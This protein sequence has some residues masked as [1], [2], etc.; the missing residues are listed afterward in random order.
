MCIR[1]DSWLNPMTVEELKRHV[2]EIRWFHRIDLGDGVVTPGL[3]DTRAKLERLK[4]PESFAG[5]SV[6]DIGAWD[7][8]F[9][10]EAEKR[11]ASRVVAM[12]SFC[13]TGDGWGTKRGFELARRVLGSKV[14]DRE[15]E[16]LDLSPETA[17]GTFDVVFFFGVLY[18]MRHPL[19][20]LEKVSSVTKSH[21]ILETKVDL[22]SWS[23]PAMA[24][25]VGDELNGDPTN[26]WAPNVAG[27][28]DMLR[29]VG[30]KKFLVTSRPPAWPARLAKALRGGTFSWQE[31]QRGRVAMHAWK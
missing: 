17:G 13:W 9:S 31:F 12:D 4:L 1:V 15:L 8:F 20:A 24:F 16:V 2:D 10:F 5:K 25:Y 7:G 23:T 29:A 11:G 19:L 6:L 14:E 28:R 22:V 27:L 30:F 3:D 26:W 21:L 18:H